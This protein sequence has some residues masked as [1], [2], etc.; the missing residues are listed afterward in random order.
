MK[1]RTGLSWA[2]SAGLSSRLISTLSPARSLMDAVFSSTNTCRCR[3]AARRSRKSTAKTGG[4][5]RGPQEGLPCPRSGRPQQSEPPGARMPECS[6]GL[7]LLQH[8]MGASLPPS[9]LVGHIGQE[10]CGS[11]QRSLGALKVHS[12][13]SVNPRHRQRER[14]PR[15]QGT[16]VFQGGGG[17][18]SLGLPVFDGWMVNEKMNFAQDQIQQ[19]GERWMKEIKT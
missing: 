18:H 8:H 7:I 16:T 11:F 6:G 10:H 2:R 4:R 15:P 3:E 12:P 9:P 13:Q 1:L 14:E 19:K 17:A 5:G